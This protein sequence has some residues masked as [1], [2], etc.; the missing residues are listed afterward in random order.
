MNCTPAGKGGVWVCKR[1]NFCLEITQKNPKPKPN[2]T[3]NNNPPPFSSSFLEQLAENSF[4]SIGVVVRGLNTQ[5]WLNAC[6]I[7]LQ[8]ENKMGILF[9]STGFRQRRLCCIAEKRCL[10]F[11][12]LDGKYCY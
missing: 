9:A 1:L 8:D 5:E 3:S 12:M 7:R 10:L 6:Y 11:L 4:H 2:K